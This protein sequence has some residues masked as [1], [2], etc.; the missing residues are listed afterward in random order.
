MSS[1]HNR[2]KGDCDKR[3]ISIE[4]L[5]VKYGETPA[6]TGV[7]LN[8]EN[9]EYLGII[10]PNGGGKTTLLKAILG[11]VEPSLGRIDICGRKPGKTGQLM[12]YVPQVTV[13]DKKFPI[14]VNEVILTGR[15]NPIFKPFHR[16][17]QSDRDKVDELLEKVGLLKLKRRMVSELS[18]GEFQK[19]LI[20]RTLAVNPKILLLDE[21]TANVDAGSREQIYSL[22]NELN[23]SITIILVTHDLLAVSSYVK[24]LACLNGRLVYHGSSELNDEMVKTLYGCPIDLIAH[25]VPHRVLKE[26]EGRK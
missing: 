20:A 23:K 13:L 4:N 3:V 1:S 7:C 17:S 26:H 25:G 19:M 9:G 5:T 18:G 16:Y 10:G 22:L 6:I 15:L 21:P 2:I 8:V 24:S 11:L 14:T 12:G